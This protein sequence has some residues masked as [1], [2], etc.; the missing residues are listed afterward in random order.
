VEDTPLKGLYALAFV[1]SSFAACAQTPDT[2]TMLIFD[3]DDYFGE[4]TELSTLPAQII[5]TEPT[6]GKSGE[7]AQEA[8]SV[9]ITGPNDAAEAPVGAIQSSDEAPPVQYTLAAENTAEPRT[10]PAQTMPESNIDSVG[11]ASDK[12]DTVAIAEGADAPVGAIQPSAE[13]AIVQSP[14]WWDDKLNFEEITEPSTVPARIVAPEQ[15]LEKFG[16]ASDKAD[17]VAIA[18]ASDAADV[19]DEPIRH[20][21][22]TA[23]AEHSTVSDNTLK[24]EEAADV[25]VGAIEPS[26][27]RATTAWTPGEYNMTVDEAIGQSDG[28]PQAF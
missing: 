2:R 8:D 10:V 19:R 14:I 20:R 23:T 26:H 11:K 25:P 13:K 9:V 16:E 6:I 3:L 12:A 4:I 18:R 17:S 1:L 28:L 24:L 27:A 22:E 15:T 5:A 21:D 7:A